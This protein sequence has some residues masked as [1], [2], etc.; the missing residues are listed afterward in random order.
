[1]KESDKIY[2]IAIYDAIREAEM[3]SH[4]RMIGIIIKFKLNLEKLG[5]M[6]KP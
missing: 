6:D 1:M 2:L 5:I 3:V 4:N